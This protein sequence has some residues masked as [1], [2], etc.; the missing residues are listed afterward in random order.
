MD[1]SG[2]VIVV[3]GG[4]RG[5]GRALCRRFAQESE[6]VVV[7]DVDGQGA[8]AVADEIGGLPIKCDVSREDEI[9]ALISRTE[10]RLG[11][12]DV[13]CSNAG[14]LTVGSVEVPNEKWQ[15]IWEVNVMAHVFAARAL[16]PGMTARG[17]GYFV[18]TASAAGL[19][20]QI[21]AAPYSVT[22]HAAVGLAEN[23]AITHGDQGI[24]VSVICPQGVNT[25]MTRDGGGVAAVDGLLQPEQ[26]AEHVIEA[27]ADERFL[28]LPHPEVQTYLQRKVS[29]VDRWLAGMRRLQTR[30]T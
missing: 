30:L 3:T 27:L 26:V 4:A 19:L 25:E 16:L 11:P 29:D 12:V 14:I 10:E 9:F 1:V 22:K 17:S 7:A 20:T 18:I 13:F 5:I 28:I 2:K 23:M 8:T 21:G 15:R 6:K 24:R